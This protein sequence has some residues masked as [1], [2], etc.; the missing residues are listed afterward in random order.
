VDAQDTP[1]DQM[2]ELDL[3]SLPGRAG[4]RGRVVLGQIAEALMAPATRRE[5]LL[6]GLLLLALTLASLQWN[7]RTVIVVPMSENPHTV[8]T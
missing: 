5:T 2:A 8:I 7:R 3:A 1:K 4:G 6:W